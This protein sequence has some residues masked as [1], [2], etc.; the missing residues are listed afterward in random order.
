[1]LVSGNER[2]GAPLEFSALLF[3]QVATLILSFKA[4]Y[5]FLG[6]RVA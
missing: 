2:S 4:F 3:S 6:S 1:M 5:S